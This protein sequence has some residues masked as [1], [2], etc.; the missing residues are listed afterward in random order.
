MRK[1]S[2]K[3][4]SLWELTRQVQDKLS[5]QDSARARF[6]RM[7]EHQNAIWAFGSCDISSDSNK[8]FKR[9]LYA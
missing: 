3:C 5:Y 6:Q 8:F 9:P 4:D 7:S 2:I 1:I